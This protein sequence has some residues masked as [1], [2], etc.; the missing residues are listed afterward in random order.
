[1]SLVG[2]PSAPIP[3]VAT[4][5][6]FVATVLVPLATIAAVVALALLP[7]LTPLVMH[8]L[9]DAGDAHRWLGVTPDVA[10]AV[11][12][13]T[14]ADLMLGGAFA[15]T[16]PDGAPFYTTDEI[17]HLHDARILLWLV[18]GT[19]VAAGIVLGMRL[20]RGVDRAATWRG[21]ARGGAIAALG[22]IGIGVVGLLAFEP[23]L[24][25]FH[26]VFF[27]G[28]NWAFDPDASRLVR[29]YPYAFWQL[30]ATGLGVGVVALGTLAWAVGRRLGRPA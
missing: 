30:A 18:M 2:A 10:H 26:R 29:L 8:P 4:T 16:G 3:A 5:R 19:G 25:L 20:A 12:D 11:S 28:G 22:A 23:L 13:A 9:L 7:L 14:V 6:S 17:A 27:P 1:M 15:V 24:E 21:I